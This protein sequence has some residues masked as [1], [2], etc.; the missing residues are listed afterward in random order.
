MPSITVRGSATRSVQPDYVV[1]RLG[2]SHLA[3]DAPAALDEVA[4][5]SAKLTAL[6]TKLGLKRTEWVSEGVNVAEEFEW[7]KEQNVSVGY[8]ATTG[9]AATLRSVDKVGVLLRDA[10][11]KSQAE[12]RSLS[13]AVDADN[14][15]RRAL[16]GDA[17]T[18]AR[19]RAESYAA[20]LGL[21]LGKVEVVSDEP[22]RVESDRAEGGA[23]M[24]MAYAARAAKET[25]P[26][27]SIS[28]GL[29]ELSAEVFVRFAALN[30]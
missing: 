30:R 6:L 21:K 12:V 29:I 18:D 8:R 25:A 24:A 10:V 4:K 20:A 14:A 26:E 16:L 19:L 7:R 1:V 3:P 27:V 22:L 28:G 15:A 17:A 23:P 2:L 11:G 13:W 5:R 9:V